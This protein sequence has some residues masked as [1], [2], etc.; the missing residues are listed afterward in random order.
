MIKTSQTDA[1]GGVRRFFHDPEGNLVRELDAL[2]RVV[3]QQCAYDARGR[4]VSSQNARGPPEQTLHIFTQEQCKHVLRMP[5]GSEQ[6][7]IYNVFDEIVS[8]QDSSDS[9]VRVWQ[10]N[11]SGKII[12]AQNELGIARGGG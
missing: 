11:S 8:Q 12:R 4:L 3:V 7:T 6:T 10:H 9:G 5:T 2:G 1:C